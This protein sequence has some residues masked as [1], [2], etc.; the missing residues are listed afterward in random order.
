MRCWKGYALTRTDTGSTLALLHID[1]DRFK[2]IND[3]LGHAAG[4]AMLI[5]VS[6][7][8]QSTVRPSDFV[9]RIGGDEF[10]VVC[11][12]DVAAN[13]LADRIIQQMRQPVSY[14]SHQCRFGVQHR[15]CSRSWKD[16]GADAVDGERRHRSLSRQE[17]W[18]KSLRIFL[19]ST[20]G[21]N[22]TDEKTGRRDTWWPGA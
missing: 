12:D 11:S 18:S 14:L 19:R 8:L 15:D 2:Q 3:T 4:D 1:L 6:K 7:L 20:S 13:M 21:R 5:H 17:L 16:S 10:V 22:H 9:A